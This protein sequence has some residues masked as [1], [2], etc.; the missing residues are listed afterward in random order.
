MDDATTPPKVIWPI[1]KK[2]LF[3]AFF[4]FSVFVTN[5]LWWLYSVPVLGY[6]SKLYSRFE[7]WLVNMANA[8]IFHIRP[9]LVPVNGSGDTSQG[10]AALWTF[11][12]IAMLGCIA[13]SAID[14]K[15]KNYVVLNYWL[16]L[17]T[18]YYVAL[19]AFAYGIIKL[20]CLQMPFPNLHQMATPLGDLLPMRFSWFFIGYSTPYQIFS[21]AM[22]TV[23]GL[24]LLFPRT[25]SLGVMLA[26]G[27]FLNVMM[28]NLCYDIPVK[29]F[30]MQMVIVCLFLLANE[31]ER[32]INFF[33]LN[34][35]AP[36][37]EL[38][39][40]NYSEKW[41]KV[42]RVIL[43]VLFVILYVG[44]PFYQSYGQ[45]SAQNKPVPKSPVKNGVYDVTSFTANNLQLLN[46]DT[47]RWKDA[48][49]ENGTGSTIVADTSF[50]QRYGRAYFGFNVD[51]G[52]HLFT[53]TKLL[54]PKVV[55]YAFEYSLPDSNTIQLKGKLRQSDVVIDLK[56]TNRHFQLA[57]RQFHWVSEHNR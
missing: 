50:R 24:L 9:V 21:G 4:V 25:T 44:L 40:F 3:R 35:P 48:I 37:S 6:P 33:I 5:P 20:F 57:E 22:E 52:K 45:Y 42:T 10:W 31:S 16:C 19:V 14:G 1:W 55:I 39:H 43:K 12:L 8:K 47:L 36:L 18:R 41:M 28:L 51:T 30:S 56:R 23:A 13:W 54:D 29:L 2:I 34:K 15:R 46:T 53:I 11:I 17:A 27:V 32:L 7:D 49:F 26:T 38:Y